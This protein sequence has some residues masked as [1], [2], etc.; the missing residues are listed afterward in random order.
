M[1]TGHHVFLIY[2]AWLPK[3]NA[4]IQT[5]EQ[6]HFAI[7]SLRTITRP[8]YWPVNFYLGPYSCLKYCILDKATEKHDCWKDSSHRVDLERSSWKLTWRAG[9]TA[10]K[11]L[12]WCSDQVRM[13]AGSPH[14]DVI[15]VYQAGGILCVG[16]P[17]Q[18]SVPTY[19]SVWQVV[20]LVMSLLSVVIRIC[21]K[22]VMF[23]NCVCWFWSCALGFYYGTNLH[24]KPV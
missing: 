2:A 11:S 19:L 22:W 4:K 9:M 13:S 17:P 18:H 5:Q 1:K 20:E 23:P 14:E 6:G 15:W 21:S 8:Q 7:P 3:L 16:L 12:L 24:E 10:Q